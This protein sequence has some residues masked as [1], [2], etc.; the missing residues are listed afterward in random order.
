MVLQNVLAGDSG[1]FQADKACEN[2]DFSSV[3]QRGRAAAER[4]AFTKAW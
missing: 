1:E 2:A 3:H 4:V